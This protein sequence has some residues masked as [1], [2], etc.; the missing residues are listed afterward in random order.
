MRIK[1][2]SAG[3]VMLVALFVLCVSGLLLAAD[4]N[5]FGVADQRTVNFY[6]PVK[7]GDTVVPPGEYKVLHTMEGDNHIMVFQQQ[8]V[9]KKNQATAKIKCDLK[10]LDKAADQNLI[11]YKNEGSNRLLNFL[12]FKGDKAV[13]QF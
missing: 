12:Q 9:S 5:K 1:M 11:G 10:P 3:K 6:D 13:H 7:I 8:N 4:L 2:S